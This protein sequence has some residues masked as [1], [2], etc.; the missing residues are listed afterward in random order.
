M[1]A[2]AGQNRHP[3]LRR[4]LRNS[5]WVLA[6][7]TAGALLGLV[8]LALMARALGPAGLGLVAAAQA[9]TRIAGR[10]LRLE[11]WQCVIKFGAAAL[12]SGAEERFLRLLKFSV[13]ADLAGGLLAGSAALAAAALVAPWLNLGPEGP[14]FLALLAAGLFINLH[15]SALA[16][17]RLLDRF[18]LLAKADVAV[19]AA[20]LG[21]SAAA[22]AAGLGIW[23]FLLILLLESLA[24]GLLAFVLALRL[25]RRRGFGRL[26]AVPLA[27]LRAENPGLLRLMWEANITVILRQTVQRLDVLLLSALGGAA[28]AGSFHL[29]RQVAEAAV[30]FVRPLNQAVYPEFARIWAAGDRAGL[31]RLSYGACGV[32]AAAGLALVLALAPHMAVLLNLFFGAEFAAAAG[33]VTL[34]MAAAVLLL[35]GLMLGNALLSMGEGRALVRISLLASVL[36][37]AALILLVPGLAAMGAVLA[38]LLM[39]TVLAGG[40][41]LAV[42]RRLRAP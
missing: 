9:Y 19:A 29:A 24:N 40:T 17:L 42:R 4:I 13:L 39:G 31:R 15:A 33:L 28:A 30:K 11:P 22:Y 5:S 26:R 14:Q 34:Q 16:V 37:L 8:S 35:A 10:L 27:G 7:R 12:E 38:H 23:G 18:D 21:L 36:F 41:L 3:V 2:R 20:R 32:L 6:A 25:L 1:S